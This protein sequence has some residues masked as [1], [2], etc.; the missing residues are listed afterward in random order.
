MGKNIGLRF[1]VLTALLLLSLCPFK[2]W[3][4]IPDVPT[5]VGKYRLKL[6]T[7]PSEISENKY[8][9]FLQQS[10]KDGNLYAMNQKFRSTSSTSP[11]KLL[12]DNITTNPEKL[13]D[14]NLFVITYVK[15]SKVYRFAAKNKTTTYYIGND[16]DFKTVTT[17]SEGNMW[18]T[19]TEKVEGAVVM[20]EKE[21]SR[22]LGYSPHYN[23]YGI[24]NYSSFDDILYSY[25]LIYE[26]EECREQVGTI[27]VGTKEG[28]GT[29]YADNAYVMPNGLCGYAVTEANNT[30]ETLTIS[31]V[32]PAGSTVPAQT[33]LLVKGEQ[34]NY[35]AFAPITTEAAAQSPKSAS[36][37][38][39]LY[40]TST[41]AITTAPTEEA[42]YFYKLY[43]LSSVDGKNSNLGFYWGQDSGG[44]F[45][46]AANK[47]YMAIKQ[48]EA[49][50]IVGFALPYQ[51]VAG[52][53]S[54]TTEPDARL[55]DGKTYTLSGTLVTTGSEGKLPAGIYIRNGRKVLIS[56]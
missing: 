44:P 36:A 40:G 5:Y 7:S 39:L 35:A 20:Y 11:N 47:A 30:S 15:S 14:D 33:A 51:S 26:A 49:L 25:A 27:V 9:V 6:V 17:A 10:T 38:N 31:P 52:M 41:D 19:N 22:F 45:T 48:S 53:N 56:K 23:Y 13:D 42:Y 37:S 18:T 1:S 29:F 54:L 3:A 32:Y 8:Y 55:N 16:N 50:Q 4:L 24:F 12:C 34:G 2:A 46:N 21:Q 28:Y 43:Y